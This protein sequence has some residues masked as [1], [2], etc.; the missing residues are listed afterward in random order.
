MWPFQCTVCEFQCTD[1]RVFDK[2]PPRSD[3]GESFEARFDHGA[4]WGLRRVGHVEAETE[5][6]DDPA[7]AR[8][9]MLASLTAPTRVVVTG[10]CA[11]GTSVGVVVTDHRPFFFAEIPS[12]FST[13]DIDALRIAVADQCFRGA[14]EHRDLIRWHEVPELKHKL[15]GF[16]PAQTG[17]P[18][19]P[20]SFRFVR[21]EFPNAA[22]LRAARRCRAWGRIAIHEH[23]MSKFGPVQKFVCAT[24]NLVRPFGWVELEE[25]G[26]TVRRLG[27]QDARLTACDVEFVCHDTLRVRGRVDIQRLAPLCVCSFDIEAYSAASEFPEAALAKD[28]VAAIG[29]TLERFGYPETR[30]RVMLMHDVHYSGGDDDGATVVVDPA[31]GETGGDDD[32]QGGVRI[33]SYLRFSTEGDMLDAFRDL[34]VWCGV[35]IVTGYNVCGF[36]YEY[37]RIRAD[38]VGTERFFRMSKVLNHA[39]TL[40][41]RELSSSAMGQ[42][43]VT[44]LDAPG[45]ATVDTMKFVKD[46]YKL[47]SYKLDAVVK[48]F[49]PDRG[50]IELGYKEMNS[51]FRQHHEE[52]GGHESNLLRIAAYCC[53]DCDLPLMLVL[54]LQALT[55]QAEIARLTATTLHQVVSRGQQARVMNQIVLASHE[56]GYVVNGDDSAAAVATD[57]D[58]GYIGATVLDPVVGYYTEPVATL[59]FMALYPSIIQANNLCYSTYVADAATLPAEVEA[60]TYEAGPRRHTF[61]QRSKGVLPRVLESILAERK[62]VKAQKKRSTDEDERTILEARQLALKVSANSVYGFCGAAQKG[63]LPLVAIAESVTANG[64]ELIDRTKRAVEE[65]GHK[66]IYGDTDSVMVI[67][68]GVTDMDAAFR[69]GEEWAERVTNLFPAAIILE[70]EKVT[71]PYLLMGKKRYLGTCYESPDGKGKLDVKGF[72]VARRDTAP[73]SRTVLSAVIEQILLGDAAGAEAALVEHLRRLADDEVP[74]EQFVMSKALRKHY[75]TPERLPHCVVVEKMRQRRHPHPRPGERVPFVLV[76]HKDARAKVFEK[77][78]DPAYVQDQKLPLDLMAYV[79]QLHNPVCALMR[80]FAPDLDPMRLFE[81]CHAR[82]TRLRLGV[83]PITDFFG[84]GGKPQQGGGGKRVR[85]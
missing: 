20:C 9:A 74:F 46:N 73:F 17:D 52:G 57:K 63:M 14:A 50:K 32:E 27:D 70:M 53:I 49:F 82:L 1:I 48:E 58:E 47:S 24:G 68:R 34:V 78:E 84:G 33:D 62:A 7:A 22:S 42:Q 67:F 59:D 18:N 41:T 19:R 11:D 25:D 43:D 30:T 81:A 13:H 3:E 23:N 39:T 65:G 79:E 38:L 10:V 61:V 80:P 28:C 21:F 36:D 51:M 56:M 35:D 4:D 2:E 72:D 31:T 45:I 76:R 44:V 29:L 60:A 54:R 64:R 77:A 5:E 71:R 8:R 75:A 66:V 12:E 55:Q 40:D 69:L 6:H 85:F 15:V 16:E 83:R 37:L 26:R